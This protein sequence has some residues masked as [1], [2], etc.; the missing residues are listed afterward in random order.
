MP[1]DVPERGAEQLSLSSSVGF[2]AR[3]VPELYSDVN[4]PKDCV[5]TFSQSRR[6]PYC[7]APQP[8]FCAALVPF[9]TQESSSCLVLL[10]GVQEDAC[11]TSILSSFSRL[12]LTS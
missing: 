5:C 2:Q 9:E 7:K 6:Y 8:G 3:Y 10:V 11:W 12:C 1:L 4:A